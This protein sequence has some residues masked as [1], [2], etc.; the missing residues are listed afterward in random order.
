MRERATR[1]GHPRRVTESDLTKPQSDRDGQ[2][3]QSQRA[4]QNRHAQGA[5]TGAVIPV[6][7]AGWDGI[8]RGASCFSTATPT[9]RL[10]Q[11]ALV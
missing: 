1:H 8:D 10:N 6:G 2:R 11:I 5:P 3:A 4:L 9:A 7:M